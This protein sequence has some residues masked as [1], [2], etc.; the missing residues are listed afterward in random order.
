MEAYTS[1]DDTRQDCE[2]TRV[3]VTQ[4]PVAVQAQ[5]PLPVQAQAPSAVQAQVNKSLTQNPSSNEIQV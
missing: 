1:L 3:P 2:P 5:A 4:V